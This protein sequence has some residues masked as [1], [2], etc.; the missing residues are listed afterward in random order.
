MSET[1]GATPPM[2]T[3]FTLRGMTLINRVV[4]SHTTSTITPMHFSHW[5][6]HLSFVASF[7][8]TVLS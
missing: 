5:K 8:P 6:I 1:I 3:P 7:R 2:L 4:M